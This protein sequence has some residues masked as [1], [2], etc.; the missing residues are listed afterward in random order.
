MWKE[1]GRVTRGEKRN[2]R[3]RTF[4]TVGAARLKERQPFVEYKLGIN[5]V[6]NMKILKIVE[7]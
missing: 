5:Y 7:V 2:L 6:V 1:I 4:K 3:G